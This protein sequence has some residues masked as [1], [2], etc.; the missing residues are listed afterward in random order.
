MLNK[1]KIS[2]LFL[3]GCTSA[4]YL[5]GAVPN[6]PLNVNPIEVGSMVPEAEL[7]TVKGDT[8]SLSDVIGEGKVIIIFYRGSWCPYCTKH[9]AAVGHHEQTI[10]KK[11]Y[12]IIAI[13]PDLP[14]GAKKYA[15]ETEFNYSIYS[16]SNL[17][18]TRAFGLAF[19]SY[20]KWMQKN[21][22]LPVPAVYIIDADG[23]VT[24]RHFNANYRERLAPEDLL[25]ALN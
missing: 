11:D 24:F 16:D 1:L 4:T 21:Q 19:E 8:V 10:L 5:S 12:R 15:G 22:T 2:L 3:L 9:L 6:D 18:T 13:S 20:S 23:R 25:N 7:I 14:E 17:S